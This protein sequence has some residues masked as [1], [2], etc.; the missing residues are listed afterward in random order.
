MRDVCV[1]SSELIY[2]SALSQGGSKQLLEAQP[3]MVQKVTSAQTKLELNLRT[4]VDIASYHGSEVQL[5]MLQIVLRLTELL[6]P[7]QPGASPAHIF[8]STPLLCRREAALCMPSSSTATAHQA[9]NQS[10]HSIEHHV[11]L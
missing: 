4:T 1:E 5:I 9:L 3:P 6:A 11:T 2:D 7:G 10:V 8:R